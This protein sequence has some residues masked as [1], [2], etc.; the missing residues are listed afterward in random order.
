MLSEY[1]F[2][3]VLAKTRQ[4]Y[5]YR[6]LQHHRRWQTLSYEP[7]SKQTALILGTGSVGQ[8]LCETACHLD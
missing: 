2:G 1:V 6:Q 8:K 4:H 5:H 3:Y 7:L